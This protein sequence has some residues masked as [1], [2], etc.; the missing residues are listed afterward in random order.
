MTVRTTAPYSS[1]QN[2]KVE[3]VHH[4]IDNCARA[5]HIAVGLPETTWGEFVK[6]ASYLHRYKVTKALPNNATPYEARFKSKPNVTHLREVGCKAFVLIQN[7]HVTKIAPKSIETVFLGY[8][9]NSK[10]YCCWHRQLKKIIIS[11]NVQFLESHELISKPFKTGQSY[12]S[13]AS[14]QGEHPDGWP[15]ALA[16]PERDVAAPPPHLA[17]APP[18][19]PAAPTA[20][21]SA[22]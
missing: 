18:A 5:M 11:R 2:G 9:T 17:G 22:A 20:D 15:G 1:L 10:S 21:K 3:R 12:G 7:E 13:P 16:N 14:G 19:S 4:T 8:D 6:T